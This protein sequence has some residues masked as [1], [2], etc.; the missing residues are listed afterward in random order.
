MIT[1]FVVVCFLLWLYFRY[2]GPVLITYKK[3]H[4]EAITPTRAYHRAACWDVYSTVD[5]TIPPGCWTEIPTGLAFAPAF[6]FHIPFFNWTCTPLGNIAGRIFT[7]SGL[8]SR[9]GIRCHLG[10]IDNDYRGEWTI[11]VHN[12]N[13]K[14]NGY[15]RIHQ[16]DKIAQI[17]FYRVLSSYLFEV[18]KLSKSVRG[19]KGF[20]SSG[21]QYS[22]SKYKAK[23]KPNS[24]NKA[25]W[26]E[27]LTGR[28]IIKVNFDKNGIS[29]FVLDSKETIHLIHKDSK[30]GVL[31]IIH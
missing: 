18:Q 13:E 1:A 28:K 15:V 21:R 30:Q 10:I 6:H 7:R 16:G 12:H 5:Y 20:G 24:L 8:A 27:V 17:D 31:Y 11:I 23:W 4:P 26:N 29:S 3:L 2:A 25:F 22:M 14:E 19:A 9:K